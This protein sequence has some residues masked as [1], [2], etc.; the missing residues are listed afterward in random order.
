MICG[1]AH[2]RKQILLSFCMQL[3]VHGLIHSGGLLEFLQGQADGADSIL[4]RQAQLQL[5][6]S[7]HFGDLCVMFAVNQLT[8]S[9]FKSGL[10]AGH[11]ILVMP[12]CTTK[13]FTARQRNRDS[14]LN[15]TSCHCAQGHLWSL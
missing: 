8:S 14:S 12:A 7:P 9:G 10:F 5:V 1:L 13:V 3:T 6:V 15:S 11:G 4:E 2:T